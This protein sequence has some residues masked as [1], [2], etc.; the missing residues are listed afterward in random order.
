MHTKL[1][2][3]LLLVPLVCTPAVLSHSNEYWEVA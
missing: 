2:P 1:R 3:G